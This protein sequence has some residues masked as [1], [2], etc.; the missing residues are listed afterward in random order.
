M[1]DFVARSLPHWTIW[2]TNRGHS[3][4]DTIPTAGE[5]SAYEPLTS[6]S[7]TAWVLGEQVLSGGLR[8]TRL[9]EGLILCLLQDLLPGETLV[10]WK[11]VWSPSL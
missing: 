9:E 3:R 11:W 2:K 4:T 10:H 5:T 6:N 7:P 1:E 8:P